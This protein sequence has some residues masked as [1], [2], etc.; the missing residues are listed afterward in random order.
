MTPEKIRQARQLLAE[1]ENTF[2]I[3]RLLGVSR[4]TV[5]KYVPEIMT[6]GLPP[7]RR[8][9]PDVTK[10]DELLPSRQAGPPR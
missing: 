7:D 5:Y 1:P 6:V 8:S 3:A 9:P 10:Y 2:S 4:A